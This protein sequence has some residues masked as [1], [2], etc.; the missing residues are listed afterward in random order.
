MT[1]GKGGREWPPIERVWQEQERERDSER[2]SAQAE[3]QM[4]TQEKIEATQGGSIPAERGKEE[5]WGLDV[6]PAVFADSLR[7]LANAFQ[8]GQGFSYAFDHHYVTMLAGARP[9]ISYDE[10]ANEYKVLNLTLTWRA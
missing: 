2:S 10:R 4:E 3:H 5:H 7:N 8:Q 1:G 6:S 9:S